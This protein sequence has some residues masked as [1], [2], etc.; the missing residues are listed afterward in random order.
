MNAKCILNDQLFKKKSIHLMLL[1]FLIIKLEFLVAVSQYPSHEM[2]NGLSS[3][4]LH[5]RFLI[6]KNVSRMSSIFPSCIS[7][8]Q[9]EVVVKFGGVATIVFGFLHSVQ[10]ITN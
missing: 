9:K 6:R 3:Y 5:F 2:G 7:E 4:S 8:F 1:T 10:S